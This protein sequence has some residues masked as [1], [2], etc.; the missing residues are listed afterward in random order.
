MPKRLRSSC[1]P[2]PAETT[3]KMKNGAE[4]TPDAGTIPPGTAI[5]EY[6]GN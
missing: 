5:Y 6:T 1:R 2:K 3:T 4:Q